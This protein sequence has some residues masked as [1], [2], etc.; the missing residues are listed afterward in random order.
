MSAEWVRA[1]LT[2]AFGAIAGG[3]TNTLAIWMI[4]H[5]YHPPT[6]LG[7]RVRWLQGAVPKNQAR[8]AGAIG[9][10]V[11]DRLLT[12]DDLARTLANPEFRDAFDERL[13]AFLAEILHRERG[14]LR[15]V[16]P[17]EAVAAV[18]HFVEGAIVHATQRLQ[19]WIHSEAFA[20]AVTERTGHLVESLADE[21]IGDLLTPARERVVAD[22]VDEWMEGIVSSEGFDRTVTD[23]LDRFAHQLLAPGR[24]F[25]EILPPGLVSSL[26]HAIQG[27]LP[28]AIERLGRLLEDEDTRAR[29]EVT[30]RDLFHRFMADLKL[31]QRI[32]ARLVV[33]DDTLERILGTIEKEGAQRLSELL[34]EPAMQ[35]AM[36]RSVNEAIVDF[37]RRPVRGVL[38]EPGSA[39]VVDARATLA[40]GIVGMARDPQ[41]RAFLVEKVQEGLSGVGGRTWGE[42]LAHVPT[43]KLAEWIV[44]A[45]RSDAARRGTE[46]LG[47]W[48]AD[49][50][51]DRPIGRPAGWL[52]DDAPER[53]EEGLGPVVWTW[54]Q[55]EVPNVVRRLDVG[56]R[57]E[58]KVNDYPIPKLEELVRR[59]TDRELKLIV[60]LGYVLGAAIGA[61]LVGVDLLF[62]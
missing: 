39:A 29:F 33:T 31:H 8:L 59:I 41:S 11:G 14:S 23:Y 36:A 9:R 47:R 16:V 34:T 25:E 51:L 6:F 18:E 52:P 62:G 22:A 7:R 24:T 3:V 38:G 30:L 35:A 42:V 48:L 53:I 5:P 57:V 12:A 43:P 37:L 15:E 58:T 20:E 54:V 55:G 32:V 26:E 21:P 46:A 27:Y 17:D 61:T 1:C 44:E 60:R 2:I 50:A 13:A 10:T 40:R 49:T 45:A 28:L 56:R 19:E 4:F